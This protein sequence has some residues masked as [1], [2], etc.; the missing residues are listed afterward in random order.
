MCPYALCS[1]EPLSAPA[2]APPEDA[3]A[4]S[5]DITDPH[6]GR[7]VRPRVAVY[8]LFVYGAPLRI[9]S[10]H[11]VIYFAALWIG[12]IMLSLFYTPYP[13]GRGVLVG[14]M[15]APFTLTAIVARG[16]ALRR[17]PPAR[18]RVHRAGPSARSPM[19]SLT[20]SVPINER[21]AGAVH[22]VRGFYPSDRFRDPRGDGHP[23]GVGL[24]DVGAATPPRT[25]V[26]PD[27]VHR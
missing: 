19:V 25:H 12:S 3:L 26:V 24:R 8:S 10:V 13:H 11:P 1:A 9:R 15:S 2:N 7:P 23:D 4:A 22:L 14:Q 18:A 20:P 6:R 21:Q 17:L 27:R 16:G 5:V